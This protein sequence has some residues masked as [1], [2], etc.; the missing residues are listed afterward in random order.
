M[1]TIRN[2]CH[3]L[4]ITRTI[5]QI[6]PPTPQNIEVNKCKIWNS[7]AYPTPNT[8]LYNTIPQIPNYENDT[9]LKFPPSTASIQ[10][11]PLTPPK[12]MGD[13][14]RREEVGYG[15]YNQEKNIKLAL[16]L[17]GLQNIFRA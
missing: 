7:L 5:T 13:I 9:P 2:I 3:N 6:A 4:N 8:Y 12:K 1:N 10:T 11:D 15:I 17:P 14:W 16:R